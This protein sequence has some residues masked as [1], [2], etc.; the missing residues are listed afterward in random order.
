MNRPR[1]MPGSPGPEER[2]AKVRAVLLAA[3]EPLGPSEIG[4]RIGEPWS[5]WDKWSGKS[6]AITP[7]CRRIG[8][9]GIN[10]KYTL[11]K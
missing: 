6:A 8:A 2:N 11:A 5:C 1:A 7:I 4:A 10:G 3:T 9:V